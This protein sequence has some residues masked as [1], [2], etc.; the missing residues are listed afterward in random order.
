MNNF[1]QSNL[2][3]INFEKIYPVYGPNTYQGIKELIEKSNLEMPLMS[4][5][6]SILQQIINSVR[7]YSKKLGVGKKIWIMDK[8]WSFICSK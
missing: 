3:K 5:T 6:A 2:N 1:N 4:Q 7:K 8:Q